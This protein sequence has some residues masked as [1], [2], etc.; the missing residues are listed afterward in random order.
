MKPKILNQF[1]QAAKKANSTSSVGLAYGDSIVSR[2][3]T[4]EIIKNC[5]VVTQQ[6][7]IQ[8]LYVSELRNSVQDKIEILPE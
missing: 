7:Y 2:D 8:P 6:L 3:S 4:A 1:D 5:I